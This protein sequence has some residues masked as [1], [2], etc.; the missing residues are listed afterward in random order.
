MSC[1]YCK[2]A[3]EKST[4]EYVEK[5]GS[6][7]VI[8]ENVPCEKCTQC[9]EAYFSTEVARKL[10]EILDSVKSISTRLTV[11]V[12]DYAEKAA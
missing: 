11:A 4:T 5:Q 7:I 2:G 12:V 1:F 6:V 9:G 3:L 8:I 10:N